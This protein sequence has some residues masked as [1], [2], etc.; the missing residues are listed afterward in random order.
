MTTDEQPQEQPII[1]RIQRAAICDK[2]GADYELKIV[3]D[4]PVPEPQAGQVLVK[5][6]STG[7]CHSDLSMLTDE[8]YPHH[9]SMQCKVVGHEGIGRIVA[10]GPNFTQQEKKQ[11]PIGLRVGMPL[12]KSIC[13]KCD[14]CLTPD[15]EAYCNNLQKLSVHCD[16]T[17]QE[18]T[19]LNTSYLIRVPEVNR[20]PEQFAGPLLCGGVTVYKAIKRANL[21]AGDWIVIF[22]AGGGLGSL[23]LF[24]AKCAGYRAIAVD[25]GD[26][27]KQ[28]CLKYGAE[29]FIDAEQVKDIGKKVYELTNNRGANAAIVLPPVQLVYNQAL[30]VLGKHSTL[31]C[32]GITE[33]DTVLSV[34]P[35]QAIF[36][37]VRIIGSLLGSRKDL[38]DCLEL[39]AQ[40]KVEMPV[41]EYKLEDVPEV[42][43]QMAQGKIVGRAIVRF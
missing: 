32:V 12:T 41:K 20:L 15:G 42:F 30:L 7:L 1:P 37:D 28:A 38:N 39:A 40:K 4:Y 13:H 10:H 24:Y 35:T 23:G 16:G 3:N 21:Q 31:V 14:S 18:Y 27:K 33:V 26:I 19:T 9:P 43:K 2:P 6:T 34:K 11:F 5:L 29:W 25:I 36:N 22:G 17:L 8:W